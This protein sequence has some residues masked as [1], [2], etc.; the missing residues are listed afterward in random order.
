[1]SF[2]YSISIHKNGP[3]TLFSRVPSLLCLR[4]GQTYCVCTTY[5][6][7]CVGFC[8]SVFHSWNLWSKWLLGQGLY[9]IFLFCRSWWTSILQSHMEKGFWVWFFFFFSVLL[10]IFCACKALFYISLISA[11]SWSSCFYA[12]SVDLNC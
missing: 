2:N 12:I 5:F 3:N 7:V 1:M 8:F 11:D 4:L 10:D 6:F 9:F